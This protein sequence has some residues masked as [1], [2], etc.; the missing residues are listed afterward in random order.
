M[1]V[2]KRPPARAARI[3]T[4]P[5]VVNRVLPLPAVLSYDIQAMVEF[6]QSPRTKS[7]RRAKQGDALSILPGQRLKHKEH[8]T[9]GRRSLTT[10]ELNFRHSR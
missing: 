5:F 3:Q 9:E 1:C 6:W 4:A 2:G 8:A 7:K 10:P